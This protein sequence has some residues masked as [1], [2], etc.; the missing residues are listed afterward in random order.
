MNWELSELQGKR[1]D[2]RMSWMNWELSELQGKRGD[3][4]MSWISRISVNMR[5]ISCMRC[6]D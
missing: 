3:L 2:L 1:G 6:I 5:L 4:R